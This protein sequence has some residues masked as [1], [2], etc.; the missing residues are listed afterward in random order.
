M[1]A[2]LCLLVCST[3]FFAA[4]AAAQ[5][6][7]ATVTGVVRDTSGA[8]VSGA[9]VAVAYPASGLTRD[10]VSNDTGSYTISGLPVG[11]ATVTVTLSGFR[12]MRF[13]A[14]LQLGETRILNPVLEVAG[15]DEAVQVS[16]A[17]QPVRASTPNGG[18]FSSA[19]IAQLPVNGRNWTN[20][21]ALVPGAVDTG[22][23]GNAVRFVGHGGDDN[24]FR[25]DGVD[26]TSVR[27][28]GQSKSRLLLSSDAVAE[29][30]VST[31]LY[32]AETGGSSGGQV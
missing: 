9:E 6:D 3:L 18:V 23:N 32:S 5:V 29:F 15:V 20:L 14:D 31:A 19:Q 25:V 4:G 27:N 2:R 30:R 13:T 26:A 12:S 21:M 1:I 8:A 28:Q 11:S 17:A 22:G 16:A 10:V 7:R 24:N